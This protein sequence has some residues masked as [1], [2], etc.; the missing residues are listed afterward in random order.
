[1]NLALKNKEALEAIRKSLSHK[2]ISS[3]P[4][5][6]VMESIKALETGSNNVTGGGQAAAQRTTSNSFEEARSSIADALQFRH[7]NA[8]RPTAKRQ[9]PKPPE[10]EEDLEEELLEEGE[11][12]GEEEG[13]SV[14]EKETR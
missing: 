1:M 11:E 9:A 13:G 10:E 3:S 2:L 5:A 6:R 7:E 8:A 14:E 12:A 4:P